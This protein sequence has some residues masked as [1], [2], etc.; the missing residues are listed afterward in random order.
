MQSVIAYKLSSMHTKKEEYE[1]VTRVYPNSP[2]AP[3]V[4]LMR[5]PVPFFPL[6]V[7][8]TVEDFV[9]MV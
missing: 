7:Q 3:N 9:A 5:S 1:L 2:P 6:N 4:S 8:L